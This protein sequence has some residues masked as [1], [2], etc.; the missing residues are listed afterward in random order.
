M[1]TIVT[2]MYKAFDGKI[3]EKSDECEKYEKR[4]RQVIKNTSLFGV[5]HNP[6]LTEGRGYC[7][8]QY[9]AIQASGKQ[10]ARMMLEYM[11]MKQYNG[12]AYSF[13]QGVSPMRSFVIRDETPAKVKAKSSSIKWLKYEV[14]PAS[15]GLVES[16]DK[17]ELSDD[18]ITFMEI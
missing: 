2:E 3:F 7:S 4:I 8:T 16:A 6:D 10:E 14:T 15:Q 1:Q 9:Y 11:Y 18:I 13:V 5:L 17:F 12:C